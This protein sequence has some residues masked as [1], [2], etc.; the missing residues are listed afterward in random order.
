MVRNRA[1]FAAQLEAAAGVTGVGDFQLEASLQEDSGLPRG[2]AGTFAAARACGK[3]AQ[4]V[5]EGSPC[6]I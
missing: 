1:A 5:P 2:P 4:R 6:S 3:L